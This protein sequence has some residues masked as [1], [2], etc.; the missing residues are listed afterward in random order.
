MKKDILHISITPG[1][2]FLV[3][4]F[5]LA[6][7]FL[8]TIKSLLLI[9]ISAVIF[10]L[11]IAPGKRFLTRFRLPE[12]IAVITL[13]IAVFSLLFF[14]IYSLFPILIN[15]SKVFFELLPTSLETIGGFFAG[16]PLENMLSVD[17]ITTWLT[18]SNSIT[19]T[20]GGLVQTL[21]VS[22]FSFFGGL[23]NVILFLL[24]TFLFSVNPTS[25]DDFLYVITPQRYRAYMRDLW[26]RTK[27]KMGQWF[28]G[29][30][31]LVF[32][33]SSISYFALLILGIPNAL[34]LAIFAGMMEI[35]PIFGPIIGAI[36]A[37]LMALTTGD[38]TT[39]LLVI[40]V[41]IIIQQLENTLIYPLVVSK[42]VGISSTLI[43]LAVVAG[44]SV[45]GFVGVLISVPFAA[46]IQEFFGDIKS[47]RI[48]ELEDSGE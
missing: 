14:F 45:A 42:V 23:V 33:V 38:L 44:A 26:E 2:I 24:L 36:P 43:V 1:T 25:L 3:I 22:F 5:L 48:K 13:Y 32:L 46:V 9:V 31:V 39:V 30:L 6:G 28:Q 37:V 8:Y 19:Q 27:V 10:S 35:L 20:L 17:S 40:G 15:Q 11:A 18:D 29:Q 12:P 4:I 47:G 7:W 16:T 34:F 41:F 21:G